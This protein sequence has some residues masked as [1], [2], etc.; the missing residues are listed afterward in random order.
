M[1]IFSLETEQTGLEIIIRV[2]QG[3]HIL[4]TRKG[5]HQISLMC[6]HILNYYASMLLLRD[7]NIIISLGIKNVYM[8][9]SSSG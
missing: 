3:E 7:I 6:E 2:L 5:C 8:D 1:L 9:L 4:S